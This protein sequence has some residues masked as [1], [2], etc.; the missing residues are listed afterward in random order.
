MTTPPTPTAPE[1]RTEADDWEGHWT[2]YAD[3]VES[4]PAQA[5]RRDLVW[6]ALDVREAR[7]RVVDF[8]SGQG[9][10]VADLRA[11]LPQAEL[12][13]VELSAAGVEVSQRKVPS[14]TFV[15][16]DLLDGGRAQ[17]PWRGWATH[18]VL[19]EVIEHV[20]EPTRVLAAAAEYLQPG[21]RLVVTVPGGPMSAFDRHIGHR[22]HYTRPELDRVLRS[23]GLQVESVRAAGFPFFTMYRLVVIA[24]GRRL[25][26]DVAT[27]GPR[28][29]SRLARGVMRAFDV[30]F[31]FNLP[32]GRTGWQ[33]VA[34]ARVPQP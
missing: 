18:G 33:I 26:D 34:V 2:R 14:A 8:G 11:R 30:L 31:R 22:R 6:R 1:T 15:Q 24:R 17:P 25:I 4:N 10:L 19:A 29:A 3:T 32:P 9:D 16:R 27:Q 28:G 23:A 5:L 20:D 12:L 21:A 13:G 7:P